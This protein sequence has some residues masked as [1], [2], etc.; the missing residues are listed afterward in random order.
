[1]CGFSLRE[2]S[3]KI[4]GAVSHAALAKYEHGEMQPSSTVLVALAQGLSQS[5]DF[6]FRPFRLKLSGVRFRKRSS[7]GRPAEKAFLGRAQEHF[8]RYRGIEELVG[9]SR[10]RS[11]VVRSTA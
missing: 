3:E 7:L 8:E 11:K 1:M 2:L 10:R 5:P 4:D 9:V 6:F